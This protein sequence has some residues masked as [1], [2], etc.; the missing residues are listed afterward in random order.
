MERAIWDS[1][2][3]CF[4]GVC[5]WGLLALLMLGLVSVPVLGSAEFELMLGRAGAALEGTGIVLLVTGSG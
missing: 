5:W 4:F 2:C 3:A 1:Q